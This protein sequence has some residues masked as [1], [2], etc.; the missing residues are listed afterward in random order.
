MEPNR[1]TLPNRT[2]PFRAT[3]AFQALA[4]GQQEKTTLATAIADVSI[5]YLRY[6]SSFLVL[7]L[8]NQTSLRCRNM[9]RLPFLG[10]KHNF[11]EKKNRFLDLRHLPSRLGPTNWQQNAF[12]VKP[13]S[14]SVFRLFIWILTTTSKICTRVRSS[15]GHPHTP[16]TQTPRPP[17][18]WCSTSV[19]MYR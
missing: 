16:F 7:P 13:F 6:R 11:L 10:R 18:H 19:V 14:T 1:S 4:L 9:N 3:I 12:T 2:N 5:S 17:T 15:R 8:K